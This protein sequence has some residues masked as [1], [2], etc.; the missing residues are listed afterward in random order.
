MKKA[1]AVLFSFVAISA[2]AFLVETSNDSVTLRWD[3]PTNA[4]STNLVF[5]VRHSTDSAIPVANWPVLTNVAGT[6][7]SVT[8]PLAPGHQ[9]FVVSAER[10]NSNEV[11][12]PFMPKLGISEDIPQ[13]QRGD[14]IAV[15][16][17]NGGGTKQVTAEALATNVLSLAGVQKAQLFVDPV[18]GND[19]Q[20]S[21]YGQAFQ[22]LLAARA[23]AKP[24]DTIFVSGAHMLTNATDQL[25]KDQVHWHFLA[26]SSVTK[27][28][29]GTGPGYG[30]LDDRATGPCVST[31]SGEGVFTFKHAAQRDLN[32]NVKGTIFT[33]NP[34]TELTI[35]CKRIEG[36]FKDLNLSAVVYISNCKRVTIQADE[37]IDPHNRTT[38][39]Y[40]TE[41]DAWAP[42]TTGIYWHHGELHTH[43]KRISV[44]GYGLYGQDAPRGGVSENWWHTSDLVDNESR[45]GGEVPGLYT[46]A[47][48]LLWKVW[49]NV[50]ELRSSGIGWEH[51]GS[52]KVYIK[53][54]KWGTVG[55]RPAIHLGNIGDGEH[56]MQVQKLSSAGRWVDISDPHTGTLHLS[57][58][59][60]EDTGG[61]TEGFVNDGGTLYIQ[62]GEAKVRNGKG[63]VHRSGVTRVAG[64]H[65]D[66]SSTDRAANRPAEVFGAGLK[67]YNSFLVGPASASSVFGAQGNPLVKAW[68]TCA[69]RP[70]SS[71][72]VNGTLTVDERLD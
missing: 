33:R 69:S 64:L 72:L 59:Q 18:H 50:H 1:I 56:W 65:L 57:V 12:G 34:E 35:H 13:L 70:A 5:N 67:L 61:L 37:I 45:R 16:R 9:F 20:G 28:D 60:Y 40:E 32:I 27:T 62:G 24:G 51:I 11:M 10:A 38:F 2:L 58:L 43:I 26:G 54:A 44:T 53:A 8:V 3:Y 46:H 68:N 48:S 25:L 22:S 21:R 71:V 36:V 52:G 39:Y 14:R 47:Q 42:G 29:P 31:V 49:L 41:E 30:I 66:T 4:L 17:R 7:T 23:T 63:I 55:R 15:T 6:R 19:S